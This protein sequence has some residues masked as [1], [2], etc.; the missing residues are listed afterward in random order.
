VRDAPAVTEAFRS[1]HG[2]GWHE[3]NPDVFQGTERFFRPDYNANLVSSWLPACDGV[4]D[5]LR[6]GAEVA[7]I[8]CG[9]GASLIM[10]REYR[11][12][13]VSVCQH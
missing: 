5:R 13:C 8:G 4:V 2:V 6:A 9:H 11:S 1:G 7:D 10:A 12:C 3:H